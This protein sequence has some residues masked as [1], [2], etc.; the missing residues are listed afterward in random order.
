[1]EINT[2]NTNITRYYSIGQISSK[3]EALAWIKR[4][5]E[6]DSL[7]LSNEYKMEEIDNYFDVIKEFSNKKQIE[8]LQEK[9]KTETNEVVRK[10]LAKKIID[11]K[12]KGT[13]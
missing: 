7:D 10:E 8:N 11:L 5:S 4:V 13:K 6:I 9:L 1:M 12:I 3:F 2:N